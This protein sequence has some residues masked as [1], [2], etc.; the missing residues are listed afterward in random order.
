MFKFIIILSLACAFFPGEKTQ[1]APAGGESLFVF[2]QSKQDSSFLQNELVWLREIA[3]NQGLELIV[4]DEKDGFP[5][6]VTATPAIMFWGQKGNALFGGKYRDRAAVENFIRISR[7]QPVAS[8]P[9][10]RRNMLFM[11]RGRQKAAIPLKITEQKGGYIK[12]FDWKTLALEAFETH[13]FFTQKDS[14]Q[15]WP[16]DRKFYLDLHPWVGKDGRVFL[17]VALFSQFDCINPIWNNDEKAF[18]G[19]DKSPIETLYSIA[20]A[21]DS[22]ASAYLDGKQGN[23]ALSPVPLTVAYFDLDSLARLPQFEFEGTIRDYSTLTASEFTRVKARTPG[24]PILTF[25]FPAPLDRY[26]GEIKKLEA[27]L[28]FSKDYHSISGSVVAEVKSMTM[29]MKDLDKKVLKS[30]LQAS[31]Y[32]EA[33]FEFR[34]VALR[35]RWKG[36]RPLRL[37]IQGTFTMLDKSQ[38]L[39]AETIIE[40]LRLEDGAEALGVTASF[41]IDISEPFGLKGPDGPESLRN[42]LQFQFSCIIKHK[43]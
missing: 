7:L 33:T 28:L 19:S 17:S 30:Y 40:P 24:V 3:E 21:V 14:F 18:E 9:D 26:A 37:P 10:L 15:L 31:K 38:P 41:Q 20:V 2:Y 39:V 5:K 4:F 29:G 13:G 12:Q 27:E 6:Q 1:Q 43:G 35:R 25:N 36:G 16:G 23:E 34:N 32:P 42:T 8:Q 22:V 11:E